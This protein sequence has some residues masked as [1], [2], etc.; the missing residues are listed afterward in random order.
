MRRSRRAITIAT[1]SWSSPGRGKA[2]RLTLYYA[3]DQGRHSALLFLIKR[4]R[5]KLKR[6]RSRFPSWS[7]NLS[8]DRFPLFRIML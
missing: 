4:N 1:T 5:F 3:I 2:E 6:L 8:E 7:M